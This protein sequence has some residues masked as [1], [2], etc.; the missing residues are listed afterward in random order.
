[1]SK[2]KDTTPPA[3]SLAS[4]TLR[5]KS[6]S[7]VQKS[8]AGSVLRQAGGGTTST[9][10]ASKASAALKRSSSAAKTKSLAGSALSQKVKRR[11]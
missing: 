5:S 11:G 10:I 4:K 3:A 8:L 7:K 2:G 6:A 1:M 9:P